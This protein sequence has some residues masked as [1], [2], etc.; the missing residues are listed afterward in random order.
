[1]ITSQDHQTTTFSILS[2]DK[3]KTLK[4]VGDTILLVPDGIV[5]MRGTKSLFINSYV[6]T[7]SETNYYRAIPVNRRMDLLNSIARE[8]AD[9]CYFAI[10]VDKEDSGV[11]YSLVAYSIE[12]KQLTIQF[13]YTKYNMRSYGMC[14]HL[15]NHI[16]KYHKE[17]ITNINHSIPKKIGD[18]YSLWNNTPQTRP[19]LPKR[20][21]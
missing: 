15:L 8:L 14:N 16:E 19:Y 1:M 4:Q 12:G 5:S 7:L 13:C 9:T 11:I 18:K 17:T 21:G 2:S 6:R 10:F 20:K 3:V